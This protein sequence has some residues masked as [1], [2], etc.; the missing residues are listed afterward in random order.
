[1]AVFKAKYVII[2]GLLIALMQLTGCSSTGKYSHS[3]RDGAPSGNID[4]SKIPNAVPKAE[5]YSKFANPKSYVVRGKRY[6]VMKSGHNYK[7]KGLASWYGTKFHGRKTSSGERYNLA[8]MTAA[9]KTL[10]IPS[11]V[12]VTNLKNGKQIIVKVN[13]RGPFHS[14]RIIDLSFVAAKKLGIGGTSPVEVAV[15]GP[16]ATTIAPDPVQNRWSPS[17]RNK[18]AAPTQLAQA[19]TPRYYQTGVFSAKA[20]AENIAK[21]LKSRISTPVQIK[22][23]RRN[24]VLVY[25]V[26]VGPMKNASTTQALHQVLKSKGLGKPIPVT[27]EG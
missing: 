5:P 26:Q 27:E 22:P 3:G 20:N 24:N 11:Y 21:I 23:I 14:D 15:V 2:V 18:I 12:R 9:H 4:V 13:D 25:R 7:A 1:M 19:D 16:G 6:S 17:E 10:P 8:G